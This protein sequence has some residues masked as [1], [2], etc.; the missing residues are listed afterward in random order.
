MSELY[1]LFARNMGTLDFSDEALLS[2]YNYESYGTPLSPK[3][4]YAVGKQ[5]L[6]LHVTMWKEDIA[7]GILWKF[8]LYEDPLFEPFHWW[9]DSIFRE[10]DRPL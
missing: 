5:Y 10:P 8:E 3:N 2:M 7:G 9:L 1:K 6:S 4:G